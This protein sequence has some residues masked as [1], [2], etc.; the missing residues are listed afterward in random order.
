M[1]KAASGMSGVPMAAVTRE[2]ITGWNSI[3]QY[4]APDL[5]VK[6]YEQKPETEIKYT[7]LDGKMSYEK[8]VEA[9]IRDAGYSAE[10]AA[11]KVDA[12]QFQRENRAYSD[13]SDSSVQKYL[14]FGKPAGI[15]PDVFF[16]VCAFENDAVAD[17]DENGK[18]VYGSKQDKVCNYIDQQN[19]T[20]AQKDNMYLAFGYSK[21]NLKDTPWH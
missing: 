5:V 20:K 4:M 15:D 14:E 7:F 10:D 18:S 3:I 21:K 11:K 1:L 6:S 2:V 9:L 8:A 16:D 17:K 13:A 12:F 19:L